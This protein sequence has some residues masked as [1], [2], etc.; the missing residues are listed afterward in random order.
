MPI[1]ARIVVTLLFMALVAAVSVVP[2]RPL[3][4]DSAFVWLIAETP[5]A[6]QKTMHVFVYAV[7]TLLWGWTMQSVRSR[8]LR[9]LVAA[10]IAVGFGA[11]MEWIQTMV[12]GRFGSV[13]DV[14]LNTLGVIAGLLLAIFV[15]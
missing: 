12:P 15:F 5:T 6:L 10:S 9:F 11:L 4:G 7:M 8:P 14:V 2:G 13:I 3:P 1:A